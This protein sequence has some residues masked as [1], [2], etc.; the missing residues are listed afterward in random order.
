M[1]V[2]ALLLRDD[3]D[4]SAV[5]PADAR[6]D[7]RVVGK[8]AIAVQ[9]DEPV[10]HRLDIALRGRAA[11]VARQLHALPR[12]AGSDVCRIDV[13]TSERNALFGVELAARNG[14]LQALARSRTA[15]ADTVCQTPDVEQ[16]TTVQV[17][18]FLFDQRIVDR[19][20]AIGHHVVRARALAQVLAYRLVVHQQRAFARRR[21]RL[22]GRHMDCKQVRQRLAQLA[23]LYDRINQAV[24]QC[25]LGRLESFRQ[26]LTDGVSDNALSR[27]ADKRLRF[28]QDDI[29]LRGERCRDAAGRRIGDDR[30]V[31]QP[32][33]GMTLERAGD[34]RHLHER[35]D[36]FLHAR[37]AGRREDHDRQALFGRTFD[38][39]RHLFAHRRAHGPHEEPR[40]HHADGH[41]QAGDAAHARAHAL[42]KAGLLPL[43][44]NLLR[45]AREAERVFVVYLRIPF[46]EAPCVERVVDA[47]GRGHAEVLSARRADEMARPQA[48]LV[49]LQAAARAFAPDFVARD[50]ALGRA[51]HP[52]DARDFGARRAEH[53]HAAVLRM[54]QEA[55]DVRQRK[56]LVRKQ[57]GG[58]VAI[59]RR[60]QHH[61]RVR[62]Q[63]V[64]IF[65]A[66]AHNAVRRAQERVEAAVL[67]GRRPDFETGL[68]AVLQKAAGVLAARHDKNARLLR[69]DG[70][71]RGRSTT[72]RV[73]GPVR[74][75]NGVRRRVLG[76]HGLFGNARRTVGDVER[77]H[78]FC[79]STVRNDA[80]RRRERHVI[81]QLLVLHA[82]DPS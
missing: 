81:L 82:F 69:L 54:R 77:L 51:Q 43:S 1:Q 47:L 79:R 24:L 10:D 65:V 8:A 11:R 19:Q 2:S 72:R 39:A 50:R 35:N 16:R 21:G 25:E 5:N 41:A 40:L 9:F 48:R 44:G 61:V 29:A 3:R 30:T 55:V 7:G 75:V 62:E 33:F 37:A 27:K 66:Q 49:E 26:L 13:R 60:L 15:V 73:F 52:A 46:L 18:G 14:L 31:E 64:G 36:A 20:Q 58:R 70:L 74:R 68:G 76:C 32:C 57:D 12:L 78:L 42:V 63:G 38:Q 45:I 67:R 71:R 56:R 23:A 4:R 28:C 53:A 59:L 80:P 17:F 22:G 34:F 6:H